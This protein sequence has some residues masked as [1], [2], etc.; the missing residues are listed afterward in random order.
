M[1][2]GLRPLTCE[3]YDGDLKTFAEFLEGRQGVLVTAAQ[4]DVAA[5]LEHLQ[6]A[7]DR[8]AKCGAKAELSARILQVA[9]A[10]QA[11]PS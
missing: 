3:A 7:L 5:F 4:Q 9:A 1:E 10:R 6:N 8:L 2:K 11:H